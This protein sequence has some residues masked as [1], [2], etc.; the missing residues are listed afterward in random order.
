MR[1][2]SMEPGTAVYLVPIEDGPYTRE[3]DR[4]RWY[5]QDGGENCWGIWSVDIGRFVPRSFDTSIQAQ[6][7]GV[8][9][10]L[11]VAP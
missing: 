2:R 3:P 6:E 8:A 7:A 5:L 11:K 9:A 1:S 10:G 4:T